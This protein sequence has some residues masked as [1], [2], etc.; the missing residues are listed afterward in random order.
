MR[1]DTRRRPTLGLVGFD[2]CQKLENYAAVIGGEWRRGHYRGYLRCFLTTE[3]MGGQGRR[4][5]VGSSFRG[6]MVRRCSKFRGLGCLV[7]EGGKMAY[8]GHGHDVVLFCLSE[9]WFWERLVAGFLCTRNDLKTAPMYTTTFTCYI[10]T[11]YIKAL[12]TYLLRS[13]LV[14]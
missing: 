3:L 9:F 6:V 13:I 11:G 8:Y 4:F 1:V 2:L 14:T 7:F 5:R 10:C 12:C